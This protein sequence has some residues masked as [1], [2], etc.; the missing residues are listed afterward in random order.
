MAPMTEDELRQM[1][2]R[3]YGDQNRST[4]R[5]SNDEK[6]A[7]ADLDAD[8]PAAHFSPPATATEGQMGKMTVEELDEHR[9]RNRLKVRKVPE[10][11]QGALALVTPTTVTAPK[12][13]P[14]EFSEVATPIRQPRPEIAPAP[15]PTR[16]QR[17]WRWL[18][19]PPVAPTTTTVNLFQL[20]R[21]ILE[22]R[23]LQRKINKLEVRQQRFAIRSEI[24]RYIFLI[25][26]AAFY[27]LLACAAIRI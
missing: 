14:V 24:A 20:R 22:C 1:L 3:M 17:L 21:D 6:I 15:S 27:V 26:T 7:A 2:D 8:A 4:L 19:V 12:G 23:K 13:S 10:V 5:I 16:L 18:F 25:I 9:S 11:R